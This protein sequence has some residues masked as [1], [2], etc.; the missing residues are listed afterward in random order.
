MAEGHF[1]PGSMKPKIEACIDFLEH[2]GKKAIITDPANVARA[3]AGET[4]THIVP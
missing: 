1:A 2:G 4:G 3:I